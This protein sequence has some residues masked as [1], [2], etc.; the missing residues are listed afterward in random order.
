MSLKRGSVDLGMIKISLKKLF[1]RNTAF[2][3]IIITK[4]I[5]I[6]FIMNFK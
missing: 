4:T 6:L 2:S 1:Y 5:I 3:K